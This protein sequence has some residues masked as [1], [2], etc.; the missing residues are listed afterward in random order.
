MPKPT[1]DL[2]TIEPATLEAVT[3]GTGSGGDAMSSML[4]MMMMMRQRSSGGAA[5]A[6]APAQA[7]AQP[8]T[9]TCPMCGGQATLTQQPAQ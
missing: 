7:P 1:A 3:G 4:P 9:C 5:P 6:A 2:A 8:G